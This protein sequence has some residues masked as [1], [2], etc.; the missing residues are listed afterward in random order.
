MSRMILSVTVL[1]YLVFVL[2]WYIVEINFCSVLCPHAV[3]KNGSDK[4]WCMLNDIDKIENYQEVNIIKLLK[5]CKTFLYQTYSDIST[6]AYWLTAEMFKVI[7]VFFLYG[8]SYRYFYLY[9]SSWLNIFTISFSTVV[10][11][12]V[13]DFMC[14][15]CSKQ[16]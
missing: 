9:T 11:L 13:Y 8:L 7:Q 16:A 2:P 1:H 4:G 15:F 14:I 10:P 12:R 6:R 3:S 5:T